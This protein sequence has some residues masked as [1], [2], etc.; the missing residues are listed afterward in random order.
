MVVGVNGIM[1]IGEVVHHLAKN[2]VL[3][4]IQHNPS[5]GTDTVTIH[6]QVV[7][8]DHV[9]ELLVTI[10]PKHVTLTIV[11]ASFHILF[12]VLLNKS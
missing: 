6:L 3:L 10:R 12:T 7:G 1:E 9:Q 5:V 4:L 11:K 8:E 2:V